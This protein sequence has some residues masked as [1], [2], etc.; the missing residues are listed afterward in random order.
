MH[1]PPPQWPCIHREVAILQ[2]QLKKTGPFIQLCPILQSF[3][4]WNN[5]IEH[6]LLHCVS[7]SSPDSTC[8][9]PFALHCMCCTVCSSHTTPHH[10]TL[11]YYMC[12]CPIAPYESL[13]AHPQPTPQPTSPLCDIHV[14]L[15]AQAW[16]VFDNTFHWRLCG[17]KSKQKSADY[18]LLIVPFCCLFSPGWP[19]RVQTLWLLLR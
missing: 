11:L 6:H 1:P 8:W 13:P 9:P 14:H 7:L 3:R 5:F 4:L 19:V 12:L 18:R 2:E 16:L 10:T 17:N 15:G